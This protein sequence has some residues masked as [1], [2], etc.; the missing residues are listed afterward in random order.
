MGYRRETQFTCL[1]PQDE[2]LEAA[3]TQP[4]RLLNSATGVSD[5]SFEPRPPLV[6]LVDPMLGIVAVPTAL[7]FVVV[8]L[9]AIR[10]RRRHRLLTWEHLYDLSPVSGQWLADRKRGG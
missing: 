10:R 2:A 3:R 7:V 9:A 8:G 6:L 1:C 4:G 5:M